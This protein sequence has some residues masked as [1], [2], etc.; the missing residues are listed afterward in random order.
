MHGMLKSVGGAMNQNVETIDLESTAYEAAKRVKDKK[1]SSLLVVESKDNKPS[2]IVTERDL[3]R[4]VCA[5]GACSK[6][7][8]VKDIMS[9]TLVTIDPNSPIEVAADNM[10]QN[11][12]RYLLVTDKDG[13]AIGII[14]STDFGKVL[15]ENIDMD[16]FKELPPKVRAPVTVYLCLKCHN[17][18][19]FLDWQKQT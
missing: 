19:M 15:K 18:Q 2:G 13:K 1:V 11:K 16:E 17:M 8:Q 12:V 5:N 6:D 4:R 14:T 7:V 3:V 10:I 9:D